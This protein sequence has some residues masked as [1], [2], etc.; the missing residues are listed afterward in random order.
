MDAHTWWYAMDQCHCLQILVCDM[1]ACVGN[2]H[3]VIPIH[4]VLLYIVCCVARLYLH[5][6]TRS[7]IANKAACIRTVCV[8]HEL[9]DH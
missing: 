6:I 3:G 9:T 2:I 4:W 8:L 1:Q 5:Q 7:L